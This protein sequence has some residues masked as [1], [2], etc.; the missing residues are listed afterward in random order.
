M[1]EV[2]R[3]KKEKEEE[4]EEEKEDEKEEKEDEEEAVWIELERWHPYLVFQSDSW[5]RLVEEEDINAG[6]TYLNNR[7]CK[8]DGDYSKHDE[9][10]VETH[11]DNDRMPERGC[12][13]WEE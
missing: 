5:E 4:Q 9:G 10:S 6:F 7:G 8:C 13:G 2:I 11:D 3:E 1:R 12:E